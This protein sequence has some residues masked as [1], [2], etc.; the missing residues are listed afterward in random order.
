MDA[1]VSE[2]PIAKPRVKSHGGAG[3]S[4]QCVIL[5]GGLGTRLGERTKLTPK[6]LLD[7][8]G[9]P[10][11]ETLFGEARR[12]G[13]EDFLLLAGHRSEAV[14]SF[15]SERAIESRF[16]CRVELSVEPAP[17]GT[18]GALVHALPRLAEDFLLLNGD[19][20]FDFNWL[21]LVMRARRDGAGGAMSLRVV[22]E[23]DRYET[24]ELDGSLVRAIRPRGQPLAS[25]WINGG[26]YY[27]TRAAI[28]GFG[29]PSSLESD[30][31]PKLAAREI[32]RA[33]PY[34]GFFIDIG[35]PES[36]A[37]AATLVPRQRRRPAVFLD[38]DGV[39]N[40]DHGYVHKPGQI[41]WVPG[42]RE[43]VKLLND[44]GY[45]LFVVTNQAGVAKGHYQEEA[46]GEL[47][48]WM[49]AELAG[50]GASIDD[51]RYCPFH[52][53][54]SVPAFRA[55]HNWRKPNPGMLLDL[56][57]HW[58]IE[59]EG[60][61]LVGDKASDIEAA[62]AAGVPGY[63]FEGGDLTAFLRGKHL[64]GPAGAETLHKPT[65]DGI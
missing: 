58:P 28:E 44:A 12:R 59:R 52:P 37:A 41:E 13:F 9:A 42:A 24:V 6:P 8:G 64:L 17:L 16:A 31:L 25:A 46:I 18:G 27:F 23:P 5:V 48:R 22:A 53:E 40:V 1:A 36:L 54:G 26:V 61:C 21:D 43:A 57:E 39:L 2:G 56:F 7:V 65:H 38:R 34:T 62:E 4:N 3:L 20:W 15:L 19:T 51:W 50:A 10:F 63:L 45:Y 47:H 30:I 11:L 14:V 33:Y 55:A 49:A 32:L 29:S 35:V 60:S